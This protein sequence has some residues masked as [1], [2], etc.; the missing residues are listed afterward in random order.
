MS[1]MIDPANLLAN[2]MLGCL[3]KGAIED[4]Q[5]EG[6]QPEKPKLETTGKVL[7]LTDSK[8]SKN[9]DRQYMLKKRGKPTH[10]SNSKSL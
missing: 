7:Y 2:A 9:R 6:W 5:K 1:P 4:L 8:S 3:L 10:Q